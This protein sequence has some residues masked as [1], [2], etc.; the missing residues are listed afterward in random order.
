MTLGRT[1]RPTQTVQRSD[2][3][4][5]PARGGDWAIFVT[6]CLV[7]AA[8]LSVAAWKFSMWLGTGA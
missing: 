6:F 7:W 2:A 1:Y 3:R 4:M 8:L 5:L